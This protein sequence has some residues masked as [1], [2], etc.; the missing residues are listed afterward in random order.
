MVPDEYLCRCNDKVAEMDD[1]QE[2]IQED[3]SRIAGP[4]WTL[5]SQT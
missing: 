1:L 5:L 3:L 4:P 2:G